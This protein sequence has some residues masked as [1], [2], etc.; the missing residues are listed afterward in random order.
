S[1]ETSMG[2]TPLEG[3]VM[4]T[5]SG[6]LD[7]GVM[8]ELLRKGHSVESLDKLLNRE[9]G[10]AGLSG[11]GND[12]RDIEAR[13]AEGDEA[14]RLA[15][16]VFTHRLRKYIGSYAAVL[17]GADAIV[18]TGGIGENSAAV[19]HRTLQRLEFLGAR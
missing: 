7:P 19:R 16:Q 2:M 6:D 3:L 14:C 12:M 15:L 18:F 5:R 8:L 4:G 9:S 1:I 11:V 17:G 13:A 10:L